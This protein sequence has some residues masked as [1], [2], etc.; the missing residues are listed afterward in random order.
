MASI[1]QL[2]KEINKIKQRNKRVE[3]D[4]AWE[5]SWARKFLIFILT[6]IVIVIFFIMADLPKPFLNSLVPALAFVLSTLS[7]SAF[8]KIWLNKFNKQ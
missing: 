7:V 6:Y 4:K 2:E 1:E 5:L 3:A 8:K